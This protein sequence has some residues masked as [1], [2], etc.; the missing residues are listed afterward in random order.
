MKKNTNH[1]SDS[2]V[3]ASAFNDPTVSAPPL[4]LSAPVSEI[5][6]PHQV[7]DS[8]VLSAQPLCTPVTY[9]TKTPIRARIAALFLLLLITLLFLGGCRSKQTITEK[10]SI[11]IDSTAIWSLND[12]LNKKETQIANMQTDLQRLREENTRLSNETSTHQI[13]YDT[14]APVNPQTGKPPIASESFTASK[15]T[16]EQIKKEYESQ[17]QYLTIEN[18]SLTQQNRCL[19]LTVEKL[20]NENIQLTEKIATSPGLNLKLFLFGLFF[21]VIL[22]VIIFLNIK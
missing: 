7:L 1:I 18:E 5:N 4:D 6:A 22:S 14:S 2:A 17:L 20:T 16:L 21:C 15:S 12:S 8:P 19:Q 9:T 10:T 13:T 11:K 3:S